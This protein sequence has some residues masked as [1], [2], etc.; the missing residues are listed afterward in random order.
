V[1]KDLVVKIGDFGLT[2]DVYSTDYYRARNR[3]ARLPVKWMAPES[4]SD[5]ISDEKTDVVCIRSHKLGD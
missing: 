1:S 2:K 5:M 3:H 4:F